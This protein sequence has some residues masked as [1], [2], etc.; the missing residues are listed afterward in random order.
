MLVNRHP[1]STST[2][3]TILLVACVYLCVDIDDDDILLFFLGMLV[4]LQL[5]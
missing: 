4:V 3:F 5:L 1:S 2:A